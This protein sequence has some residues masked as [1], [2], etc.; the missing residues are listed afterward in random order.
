MAR[1]FYVETK[2]CIFSVCVCKKNETETIK[3]NENLDTD[4]VRKN[5]FQ[6]KNKPVT[7]VEFD[8][9]LWIDKNQR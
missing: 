7:Q 4:S 2:S 8:C 1:D 3:T 6:I 5:V 9:D